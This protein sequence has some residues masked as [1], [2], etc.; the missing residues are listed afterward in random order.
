M[1]K[2]KVAKGFGYDFYCH[3]KKVT[4]KLKKLSYAVD[5][6]IA[7]HH[8]G[9]L[10]AVLQEPNTKIGFLSDVAWDGET[11]VDLLDIATTLCVDGDEYTDD[12]TY[13]VQNLAEMFP[14]PRWV[15]MDDQ[16]YKDIHLARVRAIAELCAKTLKWLEPMCEAQTK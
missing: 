10:K 11:K 14:R 7:A 2:V 16:E 9:W 15:E 12:P 5:A 8:A 4:E 6:A 13:I 1:K 3:D